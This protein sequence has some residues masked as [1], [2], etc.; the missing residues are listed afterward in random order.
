[1]RF[2]IQRSVSVAENLINNLP[3]PELGLATTP[4]NEDYIVLSICCFY[5]NKLLS[6][7]RELNNIKIMLNELKY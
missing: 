1:M 4:T 6:R 5:E 2:V 3:F 7:K